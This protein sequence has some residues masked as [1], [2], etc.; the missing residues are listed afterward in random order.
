[1]DGGLIVTLASSGS[2]IVAVIAGSWKLG[3]KMGRVETKLTGVDEKCEILGTKMEGHGERIGSLDTKVG[4]LNTRMTSFEKQT[5][6]L[7]RR[8]SHLDTRMNGWL[9]VKEKEKSD[10]K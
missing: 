6:G 8:I 10:G 1:M 3:T 5:D 9:D 4:E 7:D 2:V